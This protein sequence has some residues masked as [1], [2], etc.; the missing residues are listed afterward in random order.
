MTLFFIHGHCVTAF[1]STTVQTEVCPVKVAAALLL[2]LLLLERRAAPRD[3]R[4][5]AYAQEFRL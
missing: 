3:S 2:L 1:V 4:G 5:A